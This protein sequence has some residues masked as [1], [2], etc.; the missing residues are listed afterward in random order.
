MTRLDEILFRVN[1][2]VFEAIDAT[3]NDELGMDR[4]CWILD[5]H[6]PDL[7]PTLEAV[8]KTA[9]REAYDLMPETLDVTSEDAATARAQLAEAMKRPVVNRQRGGRT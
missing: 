5:K 8:T 6:L 3:L 4:K 2:A 9:M 7:I 1:C